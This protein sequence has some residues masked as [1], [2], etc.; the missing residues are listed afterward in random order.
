[1]E[2]YKLSIQDDEYEIF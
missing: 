2:G 1:M